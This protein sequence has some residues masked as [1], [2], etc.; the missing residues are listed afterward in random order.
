MCTSLSPHKNILFTEPFLKSKCH[1][2]HL[3]LSYYLLLL[4]T[5]NFLPKF[6]LPHITSYN[7]ALL[8]SFLNLVTLNCERSQLPGLGRSPGEEK[9]YPLQYSGLE[10]PMNYSPWGCKESDTTEQLSLS[11]LT[12]PPLNSV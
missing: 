2:S 12:V 8:H 7:T 4:E 1:H 11:Y 10:N 6:Q 9:G 3:S 5:N